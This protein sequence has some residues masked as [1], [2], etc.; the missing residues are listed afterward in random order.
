MPRGYTLQN[1]EKSLKYAADQGVYTSINYLIFPGVTDREEELEA[2]IEFARRTGLK[3]I[4][5]RNLNIDPESYLQLIPPP[6]GEM[7]RHE[8]SDRDYAAR[9]AGCRNRLLYACA[10]C[11]KEQRCKVKQQADF[12]PLFCANMLLHSAMFACYN[13]LMCQFYSGRDESSGRKEVN[14][15]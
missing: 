12:T 8:T 13:L 14:D 6:R 11:T 9:T 5:L 10:T 7:L 2:M 3:L 15:R 1:V 4:Q